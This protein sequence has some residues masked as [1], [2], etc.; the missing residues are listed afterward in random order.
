MIKKESGITLIVLAITIIIML[1]L[2]SV[3]IGTLN[4]N[5]I[6]IVETSDKMV[7]QKTKQDY[8]DAAQ[9]VVSETQLKFAT[10]EIDNDYFNEIIKT[11]EES[12]QFNGATI[13]PVY[14]DV[15]QDGVNIRNVDSETE[16]INAIDIYTKE[17]YH[18]LINEDLKI[19]G[20]ENAKYT[21]AESGDV[22]F[23]GIP[24]KWT[25]KNVTVAIK[26][27]EQISDNSGYTIQYKIGANSTYQKY[28]NTLNIPENC[29]IYARIIDKDRRIIAQETK[30]T[31][32]KIDK[33]DPI[34]SSF[35]VNA[36]CGTTEAIIDA[37]D[38]ESGIDKIIVYAK[39]SRNKYNCY[40]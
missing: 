19:F 18:I 25:N 6:N 24:T 11:L 4:Y 29:D 31:V 37:K 33:I 23:E 40:K 15:T 22:V 36:S 21:E 2:V 30:G 9:M 32:D 26:K 39:K 1:I 28:N 16:N 20:E 12:N 34:V 27:G 8:I 5:H 3:G 17:G 35:Q 14:Y 7:N 38:N 10:K 13:K